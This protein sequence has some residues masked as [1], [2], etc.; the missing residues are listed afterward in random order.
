VL[1]TGGLKAPQ[2]PGGT[3]KL[4]RAG[5]EAVRGYPA[6]PAAQCVA[7]V[8]GARLGMAPICCKKL[9]RSAFAQC[10]TS[11]PLATRW[12]DMPVIS[13]TLLFGGM[14]RHSPL[15]VPRPQAGHDQVS[16]GDHLFDDVDGIGEGGPERFIR[17]ANRATTFAHARQWR[18]LIDVVRCAQLIDDVKV[19]LVR[20]VPPRRTS[21]LFSS[22]DAIVSLRCTVRVQPTRIY[23][24]RMSPRCHRYVPSGHGQQL[25][26]CRGRQWGGTRVPDV[27]AGG[28]T[29]WSVHR[30][31]VPRGRRT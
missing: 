23:G 10:S 9:R 26:A 3:L 16:L 4:W 27:P 7:D 17:L 25:P 1:R 5:S 11:L 2:G 29:V 28:T 21:A 22:S 24:S 13:I 18:I 12:I 14:P 6:L 19:P 31:P 30:L 20:L 15:K 8:S